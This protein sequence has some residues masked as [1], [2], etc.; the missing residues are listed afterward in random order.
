VEHLLGAVEDDF[1]ALLGFGAD[2]EVGRFGTEAAGGEQRQEAG[3]T[4]KFHGGGATVE[5]E[6]APPSDTAE[7]TAG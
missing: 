2:T 6:K 5:E 3:E 1:G 7:S 4:G